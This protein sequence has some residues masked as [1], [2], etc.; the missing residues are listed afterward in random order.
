MLV[1]L[2]GPP[3]ASFDEPLDLLKDCHR[4]IEGF[5]AMLIKVLQNKN[6]ESLDSEYREALTKALNYFRLAAPRHT[7]DEEKSLFPRMRQSSDPAMKTAM[8]SI[9]ALEKE[10]A[11]ADAA[12]HRVDVLGRKYLSDGRLAGDDVNEMLAL[13]MQLESIY[14]QHIRIEDET[15]FPLAGRTL[16]KSDLNAIGTEMKNRR[17]A[18]PATG[19]K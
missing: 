13:L 4:R 17:Q 18:P 12:H 1:Q 9:A 8:E 7:E 2:G 14:Q 3:Q 5:L 16:S 10:H 15:I 19:A 11:I 6:G